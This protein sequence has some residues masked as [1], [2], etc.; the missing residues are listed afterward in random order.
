MSKNSTQSSTDG[1]YEISK[2]FDAI[3]D[4]HSFI[5]TD[6][7]ALEFP[8]SIS[9]LASAAQT[10]VHTVSNYCAEGLLSCCDHT[11]GGYGLYDLCALQRLRLIRVA[12]AAGFL[13]LDIKPL[14]LT[15][16]SGNLCAS[17]E[18]ANILRLKIAEKQVY[19]ETLDKQLSQ[20]VE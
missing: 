3:P 19:L 9:Q 5:N 7:Q 16:N 20:L 6:D 12:R 15:I 4:F 11:A 18:A 8:V 14:L 1:I 17:E 10:S 13:I 2:Y